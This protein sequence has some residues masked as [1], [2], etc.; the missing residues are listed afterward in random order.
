MKRLTMIAA[1]LAVLVLA[2][3]AALAQPGNAPVEVPTDHHDDA[4]TQ[5]T[6]PT[7]ADDMNET[8]TNDSDA[9]PQ[10]D[11]AP[12]DGNGPDAGEQGPPVEMPTPVPDRVAEIHEMIRSFIDGQLDGSLGESLQGFL[13]DDGTQPASEHANENATGTGQQD[14]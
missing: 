11:I 2:T 1:G 7:T 13:G 14:G 4:T 12:V 8:A 10:S 9:D 6:D 3:G 5:A